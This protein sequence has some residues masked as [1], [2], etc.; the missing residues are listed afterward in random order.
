MSNAKESNV[1]LTKEDLQDLKMIRKMKKMADEGYDVEFRR[2]RQGG[3]KA[4]KVKKS[5][6]TAE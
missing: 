5:I 4:L 2:E 6:I 3:Y 1:L